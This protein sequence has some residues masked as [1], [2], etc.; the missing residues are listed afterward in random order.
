MASELWVP[1]VTGTAELVIRRSRFIGKAQPLADPAGARE[2]VRA[3]RES[4][5]GCTHVVHAFVTGEANSQV[6]GSSDD[7]EP[8]GTAGRPVLEVLKGSNLTNI[9]LTVVRYYGG[10]NLGTGGLVRAYS[11]SA[12]EALKGLP[13]KPLRREAGFRVEVPYPLYEQVKSFLAARNGTVIEEKFGTAVL[14][15]GA[16]PAERYRELAAFLADI[17]S[18]AI[19]LP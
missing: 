14:M 12:R 8:K 3:E 9:L 6:Q 1:T 13:R 2:L 10:T 7:G 18:G 15:A 4:H 16:L 17:S 11:D 5:K 19:E